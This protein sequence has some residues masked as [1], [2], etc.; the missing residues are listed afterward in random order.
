M[1][2]FIATILLSVLCACGPI[3][4]PPTATSTP[5]PKTPTQATDTQSLQAELNTE[6]HVYVTRTITSNG[7][8]KPP[9]GSTIT[10]SETGKL[11]RDETSTG[12]AVDVTQ[13]NVTTNNLRV[14]GR[15]PCF[16]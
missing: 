12:A 4:S 1:R 13:P 9:A 14:Q 15:D 8:L 3:S 10:F 2:T 11:K 6:G 16:C 7:T 5:R